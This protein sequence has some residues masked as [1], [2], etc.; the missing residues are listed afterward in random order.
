MDKD[1]RPIIVT[2]SSPE[3]TFSIGKCIGKIL[4]KGDV[5]ALIGELGSGKTLF[6]QG[7]ASGLGIPDCYRI[8]SPTFNLINEYPSRLSLY[9]MDVYRL[10]GTGDLED[11][12]F[13]EYLTKGGVIVIEWAEKIRKFIPEDAIFVC[14]EVLDETVRKIKIFTEKNKL[15]VISKDLS[16]EGVERWH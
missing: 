9:H 15:F 4:V 7:I 16:G 13:E 14:F 8:T 1:C 11:L 10:D 3:Q 5:L 12:G 2:S 6:T